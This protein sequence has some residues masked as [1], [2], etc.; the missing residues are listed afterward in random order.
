MRLDILPNVLTLFQCAFYQGILD[1][2]QDLDVS[3]LD[4]VVDCLFSGG[5]EVSYHI[6]GASIKYTL[7]KDVMD[8]KYSTP[9]A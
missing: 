3:L 7:S 8:I 4:R 9:A 6:I 2:S 5:P 1:F